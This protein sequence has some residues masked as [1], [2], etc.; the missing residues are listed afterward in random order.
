MNIKNWMKQIEAHASPDVAK[1]LIGN[2]CDREDKKVTTEEGADLAR[3]YGIEFFET[4]AKTGENVSNAFYYIA[5]GI[6]DKNVDALPQTALKI[7]DKKGA[8]KKEAPTGCCT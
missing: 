5:K 1:I 6:K 7:R 4:S 2:K 3:Q 8:K